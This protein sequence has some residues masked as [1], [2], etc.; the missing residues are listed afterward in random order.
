MSVKTARCSFALSLLLS[1]CSGSAS[2]PDSAEDAKL[3]AEVDKMFRDY[4]TGSDN[5]PRATNS[6][7]LRRS[8]RLSSLK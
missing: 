7:Y 3:S 2:A 8:E 1:A 6:R 5:S 4:Q